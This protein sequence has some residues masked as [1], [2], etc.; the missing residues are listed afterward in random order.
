MAEPLRRWRVEGPDVVLIV[1]APSAEVAR[2][3]A[4]AVLGEESDV[5]FALWIEPLAEAAGE[6][7]RTA[8]AHAGEAR[9]AKDAG[10][11]K[12]T[13]ENDAPNTPKT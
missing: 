8:T 5:C 13:G 7:E 10:G 1:Q 3:K 6:A 4:L 11:V 9:L 2:E 12:G